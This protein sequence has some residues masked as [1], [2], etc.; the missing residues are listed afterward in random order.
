M[1]TEQTIPISGTPDT[2]SGVTVPYVK[3]SDLE[4]YVGQ[5]KVEKVVLNNAGAGY[6]DATN[7]AL[8][9]S[10]GGG[11]SAALTVDV[12]SG[13]VS[14]DNAGVPTNKG[15]GYTTA[16]IVGFGNISGGT[17]AAATAEIF[18][19]NTEGASEDYTIS[20]TSGSATI[21][22]TSALSD[23][24]TK[25]LVKRVT[26]V[27]TAANTFNAGSAITAADLNNSFNQLRYKAEELP[28]VTTTA[29]TNGDKNEITVSGDNWTI[30]N[31]AVTSAK[32]ANDIDIAGTLDVTG[33]LTVDTGI[34]PDT[35]EGAYL[36]Q[37]AK[38]FSEAHIGEIKIAVTDDNT[39][40][41]TSGNLELDSTGGTTTID[42]NAIITGSLAANGGITVDTDKFTVAD[43]TGNTVI[44]GTLTVNTGIIPDA[45]EG[46]YIGQVALPFSEAFVG[47]IKIASTDDNTIDTVS[48]NLEL[49]SATGTTVIDD[50]CN[51]NG[52]LAVN[53]KAT[54]TGGPLCLGD[55][56]ELTIS[57][58]S[59]TVTT[60]YHRVD[61]EGDAS[62]D[63]LDKIQ[64][65]AYTTGQLLVLRTVHD[66]RDVQIRHNQHAG[67]SYNIMCDTNYTLNHNEDTM[68]FMWDVE[69]H[70]IA[71]KYDND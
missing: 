62:S 31:G 3:T 55:G 39:I 69:W 46:A 47:E 4:I 8:E 26:D 22:F 63:D 16:P 48:G 42:D 2:V 11:S 53:G 52:T 61:T 71:G 34:R 12:S 24:V 59:I 41:T 64:C 43:S 5:D 27:S 20:G 32:L 9:F 58:G 45:D 38:P 33:V 37:V 23:D 44:D 54:V 70:R 60:S 21:N 35:D 49:D 13:Q 10:G 7:A 56:S 15:T 30:D 19:K 17:G 40:D 28:N 29:L 14:L 67:E 1:A 65:A 6:A 50:N 57:S 36:G 51:V 66:N 18:V 25:V 68:T